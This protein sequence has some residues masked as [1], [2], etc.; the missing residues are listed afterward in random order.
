MIGPRRRLGCG[1]WTL[2]APK[3]A[4]GPD[5]GPPPWCRPGFSL[6]CHLKP[7]SCLSCSPVSFLPGPGLY[8]PPLGSLGLSCHVLSPPLLWFLA[9]HLVW[10]SLIFTLLVL[11]K[12]AGGSPLPWQSFPGLR[13][14]SLCPSVLTPPSPDLGCDFGQAV[15]PLAW[16]SLSVGLRALPLGLIANS[17]FLSWT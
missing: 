14:P 6:S 10:G 1:G 3:K 16:V 9:V 7:S 13:T 4:S 15:G 8:W 2:L 17:S 12:Q 5:L 11:L